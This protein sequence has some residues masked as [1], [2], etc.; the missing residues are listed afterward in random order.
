M[1]RAILVKSCRRFRARQDACCAWAREID[2]HGVPVR[3]V[4][5]GGKWAT[6]ISNVLCVVTCGDSY[7]DNSL[8]VRDAL[9]LLL[10]TD[11]THVF[12]CDDD[13]FVHPRRWLAH[14]PQGDFEGQVFRP[15]TP[16]EHKLNYGRPW[17]CGGG[18][19]WMSRRM[20]ELYIEHVTERCSCDDVLA[21]RVAQ[22]CGIEIVDRQDLYG[23]NRY[24]VKAGLVAASNQLITCHPI[25]PAEMQRLYEATHEL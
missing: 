15:Q 21:A 6:I 1:N 10:T 4:E 9:R 8:K 13:T 14:A 23:C 11:F 3:F 22:D 16:R 25:A 5:G 12:V 20:C 18:G 7:R 17:I 19:W 24:G 2:H